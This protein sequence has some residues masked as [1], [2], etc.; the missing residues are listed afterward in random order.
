METDTA[1]VFCSDLSREAGESMVGTAATVE[2]WFLLEYEGVWHAKATEENDLPRAVQNWLKEQLSSVGDG[3]L[4]FIKQDRS[5][6]RE[7]ISFF[8]ALPREVGPS[9]YHFQLDAYED[10]LEL[11]VKAIASGDSAYDEFIQPE[12]LY[13]VC[14]NGKRDRCCARSGLALF[15]G[16]VE[17]A[18]EAVWQSTHLG[19]HRFAPTLL[20]IPDGAYYGRLTPAD[21]DSFVRSQQDGQLYLDKL[22][23]LCYYDKVTQAADQFLRQKTGLLERSAYRLS[24]SR[25]L[26]EWHWAVTFVSPE[27]GEV[28]QL[29]LAQKLSAAEHVVSC[30]P[31]KTKAVSHFQFVNHEISE[32]GD[33]GIALDL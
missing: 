33:S 12:S 15:H 17:Y 32:A 27:L 5:V 29:T 6:G 21:L 14:T 3:R 31:L 2:T 19:G 4:Q 28:H 10:L 13:L 18:G 26:D 22:R 25:R 16:L 9:C 20:T 24:G 7:G 8:V 11:D 23:G 30:S 1:P